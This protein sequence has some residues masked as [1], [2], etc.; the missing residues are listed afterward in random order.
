AGHAMDSHAASGHGHAEDGHAEDDHAEPFDDSFYMYQISQLD[1][2]G[3]IWQ[4]LTEP[5]SYDYKKTRNKGYNEKLRM[6]L[7]PLN[8][9]EREAVVTFVLGLV[10]EPPATEFV[11]QGDDRQRAITEGWAVIQKFNCAGCHMFEAEQW[12]IE[13]AEGDIRDPQS[14]AD[15]PFVAAHMSNAA[16]ADSAKIDPKRGVLHATLRGV[17]ALRNDDALPDVL[18]GEGDPIEPEDLAYFDEN[19]PEFDPD[20]YL[21]P[22]QYP[23]ELWQPAAI[24]GQTYDVGL[25]RL[26]I[27]ETM[28][29]KKRP[30]VGGDLAKLLLP[31]VLELEKQDNPAANGTETW[32][33]VPPPLLG[34]GQKVK[35][36][37]LYD[38][39]LNP[40]PIRPAVFLRMPKFNLSPEDARKIVNYFAAKDNANYP[41]E[42]SA[43]SQLA[44]LDAMNAEFEAIH[45]T[46]ESRF[47]HAMKI[48]T[49]SNY[50]IKCHLI[51]DY[52]PE[53]SVRALAPDLSMSQARLRP[54][55]TRKWIAK[56]TSILPYTPMPVNI[57]YEGGVSQ[58]LYPGTSTEQVD[59]LVDLLMN[60]SHY[61]NQQTDVGALVKAAASVAP[62]PDD[63]V[64]TEAL[65]PASGAE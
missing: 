34:E 3:F 49:N 52:A 18:D 61:T 27:P 28:I 59:A 16:L 53:G 26:T 2:S 55:Y 20:E 60:Y 48:V 58:E 62:T 47:E 25:M 45:D 5:R 8:P 56:P 64:E 15:Y 13:F 17:Q 39:M 63:S 36:D 11:Y 38:F 23:F 40:Y 30:A 32:G 14:P 65:A 4:K 50:C 46:T 57:P 12:D 37:W 19:H 29:K 31:R 9:E 54:G 7:F 44:E 6:P 1:R 43:R 42:Y 10:A 33:W 41:F 21:L 35:P 51:G 22:L 24:E